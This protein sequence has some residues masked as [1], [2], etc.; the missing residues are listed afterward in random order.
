MPASPEAVANAS[1][2]RSFGDPALVIGTVSKAAVKNSAITA[3]VRGNPIVVAAGE[4]LLS[5]INTFQ[6]LRALKPNL[7]AKE[8][9]PIAPGGSRVFAVCV[10]SSGTGIIFDLD[11]AMPA[12]TYGALPPITD[13]VAIIGAVKVTNGGSVN[14]VPGTTLLDA[15]GLTVKYY[16]LN[17]ATD[18]PLT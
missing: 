10:N 17:V 3:T 7:S 16:D 1:E 8:I 14:F 15:A 18:F 4:I 13:D 6:R 9:V 2:N 12:G 5:A 11:G